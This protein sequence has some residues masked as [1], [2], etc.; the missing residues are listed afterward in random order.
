MSAIKVIN[1]AIEVAEARGYR[2]RQRATLG[3][4]FCC[5]LGAVG[6][7]HG[8]MTKWGG[9]SKKKRADIEA[10]TIALLGLSDNAVASDFAM[11]FDHPNGTGVYSEA[12]AL[13]RQVA[14]DHGMAGCVT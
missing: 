7:A 9:L 5:P 13:G 2:L 12:R 3:S 6:L 11:G 10:K 1:A 14:I 8:L 4:K